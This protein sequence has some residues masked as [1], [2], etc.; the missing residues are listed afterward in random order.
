VKTP[1]GR[2]IFF[3]FFFLDKKEPKNQ[4]FRKMAKN[5][6]IPLPKTSLKP[7]PGALI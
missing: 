5:Y 6:C 2:K 3:M 7:V 4:G 1:P